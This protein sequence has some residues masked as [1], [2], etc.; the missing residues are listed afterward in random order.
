[1]P[2]PLSPE[3]VAMDLEI[4]KLTDQQ[5]Q[6]GIAALGEGGRHRPMNRGG[7]IRA[8]NVVKKIL[9]GC[10]EENEGGEESGVGEC[11]SNDAAGDVVVCE[12]V[13]QLATQGV[14]AYVG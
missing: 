3:A 10:G 7:A 4:A 9:G 12:P 8:T 2:P 11:N 5:L 1:M 14:A 6:V 13:L